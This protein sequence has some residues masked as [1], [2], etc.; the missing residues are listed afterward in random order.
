MSTS[1]GGR[2]KKVRTLIYEAA[3]AG[4]IED[5]CRAILIQASEDIDKRSEGGIP[6]YLMKLVDT[7]AKHG[8]LR[9]PPSGDSTT[10]EDAE[11]SD[12]LADLLRTIQ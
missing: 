6:D 4:T 11:A 10:D 12:E 1:K 3:R 8:L 5:V 2:P 9:R 7:M